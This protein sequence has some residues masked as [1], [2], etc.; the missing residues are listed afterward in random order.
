MHLENLF[1]TPAENRRITAQLTLSPSIPSFR[2]FPDYQFYDPQY[3]REGFSEQLADTTTDAQGN[4]TL[5]LNLQRFARATYRLH[6]VAQGFEAD[7]GR[8]VTAE[9]AQLVSSMP[10]PDRLQ[11]RW[12]SELSVAQRRAQRRT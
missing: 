8:G 3:A 9:A 7:G 2:A 12:R 5:A 1:G 11:G 4:A 6:L 10:L